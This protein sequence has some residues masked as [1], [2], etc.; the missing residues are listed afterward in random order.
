ML[1]LTGRMI[2]MIMPVRRE[3]GLARAA[4]LKIP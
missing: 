1:I 4:G 3:E 2:V